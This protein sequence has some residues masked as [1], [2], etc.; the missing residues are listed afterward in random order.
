MGDKNP[1]FDGAFLAKDQ[2]V[3]EFVERIRNRVPPVS[4]PYNLM[5]IGNSIGVLSKISHTIK[6]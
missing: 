3:T 6:P 4:C 2:E 5:A 1:Y